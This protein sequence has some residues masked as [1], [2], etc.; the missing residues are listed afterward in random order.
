MTGF[1]RPTM[2]GTAVYARAGF[3]LAFVALAIYAA[4]A[5]PRMYQVLGCILAAIPGVG[6]HQHERLSAY[7]KDYEV[8]WYYAFNGSYHCHGA[9]HGCP[10]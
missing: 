7:T 4:G 10:R 6:L 5:C 8:W 3:C 9:V 2:G 1:N